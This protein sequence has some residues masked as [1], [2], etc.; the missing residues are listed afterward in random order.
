MKMFVCGMCGHIEFGEA[1]E[2]CPVCGAPKKSF[3]EDANA[4]I[5]PADPKNLTE[6]DKKHIPVF[7]VNKQCSLVPG[8]VDAHIKIGEIL[9]VMEAKHW[10]MW[11]DVY[12]DYKWAARCFMAAEKVHPVVTV[13][14]KSGAGRITAI[15]N[16]NVHGKW[17]AEVQL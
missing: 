1:P 3:K 10:I 7:T 14:F 6:G 15:E 12:Q 4:L 9:H 5:Q 16:C 17:M 11:I 2:H 8:C 13:H